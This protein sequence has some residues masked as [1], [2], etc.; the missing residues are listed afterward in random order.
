MVQ[1]KSLGLHGEQNMWRS[2]QFVRHASVPSCGRLLTAYAGTTGAPGGGD[3]TCPD[4]MFEVA[5]F[6]RPPEVVVSV[7]P[8]SDIL[9]K[10]YSPLLIGLRFIV[11]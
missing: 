3:A 8:C 5:L 1:Q 2:Y 7:E 6:V 4:G 9:A 11:C 10:E